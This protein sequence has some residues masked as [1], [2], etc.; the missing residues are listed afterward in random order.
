MPQRDAPER[1]TTRP[2][3]NDANALELDVK[4]SNGV[5]TRVRSKQGRA[6]F[7]DR[8]SL[9]DVVEGEAAIPGRSKV[10]NQKLEAAKAK[11]KKS[12]A[13]E[14]KVSLDVYIPSVV[15][16]GTLARLLEVPLGKYNLLLCH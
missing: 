9:R 12:R 11:K 4:D 3:N 13:V 10:Q 7:K 15:S 8:R 2:F 14:K 1:R 6:E 5:G 16:V